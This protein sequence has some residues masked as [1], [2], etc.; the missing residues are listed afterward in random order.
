MPGSGWPLAIKAVAELGPAG[1]ELAPLIVGL[2][3]EE[4]ERVWAAETALTRL[5]PSVV[6]LLVPILA[7]PP[8]KNRPALEAIYVSLV[9]YGPETVRAIGPLFDRTDDALLERLLEL[10]SLLGPDA[11]P[12]VPPVVAPPDSRLGQAIHDRRSA[13]E[14]RPCCG[15][16]PIA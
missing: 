13:G 15:P 10:V 11:R 7:S 3:N 16:R 5:G 14:G 12:I 6:P 8:V 1:G 9:E 4:Y 2:L